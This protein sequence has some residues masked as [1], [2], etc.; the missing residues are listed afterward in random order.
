MK[1][2]KPKDSAP[3]PARTTVYDP[4][5][6]PLPTPEVTESDGDT[7]WGLW[8]SS[9]NSE[10]QDTQPDAQDTQMDAPDTRIEAPDTLI[11]ESAA[12]DAA[13]GGFDPTSPSELPEFA[14]TVPPD[15]LP[16]TPER[17]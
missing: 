11:E 6:D 17:R 13:E 12:S 15:A 3:K 8:E 16:D 2:E 1:T 14:D 5:L 7:I 4:L 10:A 9:L